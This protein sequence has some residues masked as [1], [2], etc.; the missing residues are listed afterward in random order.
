MP[1]ELGNLSNLD[2]LQL[3]DNDLSGPIPLSF[4]NLNLSFFGFGNTALCE[5]IDA[6]FQEW[7]DSIAGAYGPGLKC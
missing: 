3:S 2:G 6:V 5:P 4:T 1:V 7:L